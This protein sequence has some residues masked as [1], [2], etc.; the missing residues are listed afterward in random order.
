MSEITQELDQHRRQADKG[1]LCWVALRFADA[2]DW[3]D[4]RDIDKHLMAWATFSATVYMLF[5]CMEYAWAHPE[6]PGLEIG[7]IIAALLTPWTPV[8]GAVIKWYFA[9]RTE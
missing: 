9:S 8:Q 4:D 7:L 5:W 6:K 3:V 2:W 1:W